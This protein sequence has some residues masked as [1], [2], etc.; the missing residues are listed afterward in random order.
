MKKFSIKKS[1]KYLI[2]ILLTASVVATVVFLPRFYYS[3]TDSRNNND[4]IV[5]T[6]RV[7]ADKTALSGGEFLK[8]VSSE[9][10]VWVLKNS[11]DSQ[12]V[13]M[14]N[15]KAAIENL[16]RALDEPNLLNIASYISK[17]NTDIY[18]YTMRGTLD[19]NNLISSDFCFVRFDYGEEDEPYGINATMLFDKDN[20][21]VYE[22]NINKTVMSDSVIEAETPFEYDESYNQKITTALMSYW[23]VDSDSITVDITT[24]NFC[25]NIYSQTFL[26]Y[27]RINNK[28]EIIY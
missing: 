22:L 2:C 16:V 18:E 1:A 21:T 11:T 17:N 8:L 20:C 12:N 4:N 5:E 23:G 15:A 9:D 6:F 27:S 3:V 19:G 24:E 28:S 25:I 7:T 10:T 14:D 26:E 13:M